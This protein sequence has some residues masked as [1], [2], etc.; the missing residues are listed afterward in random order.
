MVQNIHVV[1]GKKNPNGTIR[2]R[3]T[4]PIE[5]VPFKKQSIFFQYLPYWPD[6][7]VP[8]AIDAMHVQKNVF[9]SLMATLM[10]T[11]KSK[12]GLRSRKDMVQL[13]VM[14]EL[15][16]VQQDNGKYSLPAAS[17]NLTLEE[18]RAI[19]NFLRG[20]RVPTGFS[21]NPKKLVSMKDLSLTYC[22]AHDCHVMLTVFL[23]IAIRAI[24]PEFLKMAITRM[25]YFFSK[26]SQKTIHR[27]E[28]S[29]L[30]EFMVETQNQLEM[31]LPPAFFDIMVHLMI[32]LVHQIEALGPSFLHEMWSYER[33]MSVLSRYVH[34]RTHPEGS[35][36]EGY[37][38]EEVVE[39]CQEWLKV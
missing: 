7:E 19:C 26:I 10:E 3:S 1:Y 2:D 35:M 30:H 14:R 21:A 24:K 32:H 20:V 4:P 38:S 25:C 12:D 29:D 37:N 9:E 22:K 18:R 6:L 8:H 16:P 28:L 27:Q 33:F 31:C 17:F 34:N 11:G 36:I 15:W 39:C 5:G 13:N 23:P